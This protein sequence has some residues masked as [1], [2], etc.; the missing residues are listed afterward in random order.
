MNKIT[1]H[2]WF[3]V[4]AEE[5]AAF[6]ASLFGHSRI[7]RKTRYGKAGF[8]FHGQPEGRLMTVEFELEGQK[9][10]GLNGGPIFKFTPAISFLVACR[11]KEDVD[12]L[13]G[14]LSAGGETQ[15]ALGAY[16]FSERYGWTHD[17]YG[18]S[19]Q[20]MAMG[21]RKITQ[22][23]TPTLMFVGDVSGRAEEAVRR[24]ASLFSDSAIGEIMRYGE[25][26]E[27]DRP[28]TIRHIGFTLE[29]QEFA[30][31]DSARV[32][33]FSFTEAISFMVECGTQG[34]IDHFWGGLSEGG[35]P[36]AQQCGWLK[37]KFGVSWQVVPSELEKMIRDPDPL[38]AERVM[39][40][41]LKM[42]KFDIAELRKAYGAS[43]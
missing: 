1:P 29:G 42:K 7:G 15:M 41:F 35:D 28:G 31:M 23:I 24:Y 13:W 37:D 17:R 11:N 21:S 33:G 8:E 9:F 14:P 40:A 10:I 2:L 3:D 12:A 32:H 22:R 34:E 43:A 5:A 26:E 16:P 6:Y 39:N 36:R 30:A 20:V 19:W 4:Q 18:L 38:K 25:S 27:P